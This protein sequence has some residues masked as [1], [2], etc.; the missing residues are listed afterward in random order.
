[1]NNEFTPQS[2]ADID[3]LLATLR[4]RFEQHTVRHEGITWDQVAMRLDGNPTA[5]ASLLAMEATGG[6]PDVIDH[7]ETTD[8]FMFC[9][10]SPESPIGRRNV[11][12]DDE[13]LAARKQHKPESSA[14]GMCA[15]MGINLL[16]ENLYRH[17]Q[18]LGEF[19]VKTSSWI[20]TPESVR[21]RGGALFCDRRFDMVF[22]YHNGADSYY[23]ARG[24]RG[25]LEV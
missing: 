1:M 21:T 11:C 4:A 5:L 16:T 23:G 3:Q 19:D 8:R 13:A 18:T 24:F 15:Q 2:R 10:C 25:Y 6:Q 17:L 14:L 7:N 9:D 12:Y 20:Y 22:V